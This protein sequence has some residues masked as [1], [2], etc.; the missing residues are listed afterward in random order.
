MINLLTTIEA[1]I[2]LGGKL[3]VIAG[4]AVSLVKRAQAEH[5]EPT[6][7]ELDEVRAMDDQTRDELKQ[8]IGE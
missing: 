4:K 1:I 5:R 2:A 6:V 7:A 3:L 8:A